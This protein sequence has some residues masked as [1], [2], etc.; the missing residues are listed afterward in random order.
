MSVLPSSTSLVGTS[1]V[2]QLEL[3]LPISDW[4]SKQL[5]VDVCK[6]LQK[7]NSHFQPIAYAE[8][9][10]PQVTVQSTTS[11]AARINA[12]LTIAETTAAGGETGDTGNDS[13]RT[14]TGSKPSSASMIKVKTQ[15]SMQRLADLIHI[16]S[17]GRQRQRRRSRR[18]LT[19]ASGSAVTL[20]YGYQLQYVSTKPSSGGGGG[21]SIARHK[22]GAAPAF[23]AGLS[24]EDTTHKYQPRTHTYVILGGAGVLQAATEAA[25][26]VY[27]PC[28]SE[29]AFLMNP[30][31]K[32]WAEAEP[33]Q[34]SVI[35]PAPTVPLS[36]AVL[37]GAGTAPSPQPTLGGSTVSLS[38]ADSTG[39]GQ[40]GSVSTTAA[41]TAAAVAGAGGVVPPLALFQLPPPEGPRQVVS[42]MSVRQCAVCITVTDRKLLVWTYNWKPGTVVAL[43]V[44]LSC[45]PCMLRCS[46]VDVSVCMSCTLCT[47]PLYAVG[48]MLAQQPTC[49]RCQ[50]LW[51][52]RPRIFTIA[53]CC[54][55]T[56]CISRW[57]CSITRGS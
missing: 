19:D 57:V 12:P 42:G 24:G 54:C 48:L 8:R 37:S 36:P 32:L 30:H 45:C 9:S 6:E 11:A 25:E 27:A 39:D 33:I 41:A 7:V 1:S 31:L 53:S 46:P 10:V 15:R 49:Q 4:G 14:Q 17:V 29:N 5:L 22:S 26:L 20:S 44:L 23:T 34:S 40:V 28:V 3:P 16:D 18:I 56:S 21:V 35:T 50:P 43:I 52:E 2:Q 13:P 51:L 47:S 38:H 55:T